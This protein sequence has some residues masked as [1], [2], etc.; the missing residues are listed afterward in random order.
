MITLKGESITQLIH[1]WV[2]AAVKI[3][4]SA[5]LEWKKLKKQLP[6]PTITEVTKQSTRLFSLNSEFS[7]K[8]FIFPSIIVKLS[9]TFESI[10]LILSVILKLFTKELCI[11][12]DNPIDIP[13]AKNPTRILY[14]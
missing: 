9:P 12:K 11:Y 14:P 1:V 13:V 2:T 3:S 5:I 6:R 10:S 8:S 4:P 7:L